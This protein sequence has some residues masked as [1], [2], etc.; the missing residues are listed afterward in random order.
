MPL[1]YNNLGVI[2]QQRERGRDSFE[3]KSDKEKA[4]V[5]CQ[6]LLSLLATGEAGQVVDLPF[7]PECRSPTGRPPIVLASIKG[8]IKSVERLADAG[9]SVAEPDRHGMT[10]LSYAA[11]EGHLDVAQSLLARGADCC[12]PDAYGCTALHKAASWCRPAMLQLFLQGPQPAVA[13]PS[14]SPVASPV[15]S[16][17]SSAVAESSAASAAPRAPAT[18]EQRPAG[19]ERQAAVVGAQATPQGSTPQG[20]WTPVDPNHRTQP[21]HAAVSEGTR[22]VSLLETPLHLAV[23]STRRAWFTGHVAHGDQ[24]RAVELLLRCGADPNATDVNGDTPFLA[25]AKSGDWG[26]M[27]RLRRAGADPAWTNAKGEDAA[28]LVRDP[29]LG[30]GLKHRLAAA[31]VIRAP[32]WALAALEPGCG[33]RGD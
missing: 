26:A 33:S 7:L 27:C 14:L 25:A 8:D 21:V 23:S 13:A 1:A 11:R 6:R 9:Y 22:A 3:V 24:R 29:Q 5:K 30:L 2:D 4:R 28:N 16:P 32:R 17:A 12:A 18:S 31:T 10:P 15:A 19:G 20:W